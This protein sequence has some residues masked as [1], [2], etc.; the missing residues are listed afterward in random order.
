M[1]KHPRSTS[2]EIGKKIINSPNIKDYV[3]LLKKCKELK[4]VS[5][6]HTN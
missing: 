5:I 6:Q 3:E 4:N 2:S 1:K